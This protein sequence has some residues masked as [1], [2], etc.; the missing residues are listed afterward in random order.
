MYRRHRGRTRRSS[1]AV[2]STPDRRSSLYGRIL[3]LAVCCAMI[4]TRSLCSSG[5]C[6]ARLPTDR[7]NTP[8]HLCTQR[9][10]LCLKKPVECACATQLLIVRMIQR[11][12]ERERRRALVSL[13][14]FNRQGTVYTRRESHFTRSSKLNHSQKA[15]LSA[16][17]CRRLAFFLRHQR[18]HG[19]DM[20]PLLRIYTSRQL[21]LRDR[22]GVGRRPNFGGHALAAVYSKKNSR[23]KCGASVYGSYSSCSLFR[24]NAIVVNY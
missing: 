9:L 4:G 23:G 7:S 6:L 18:R 16:V 5:T 17:K 14:A 10:G 1:S 21:R 2:S 15:P 19:V 3:K 13:A 8:A 20:L 22:V 24:R 11:S 12:E